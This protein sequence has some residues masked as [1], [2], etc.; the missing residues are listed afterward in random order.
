MLKSKTRLIYSLE[1]LHLMIPIKPCF[2]TWQQITLCIMK[3]HKKDYIKEGKKS[4]FYKVIPAEFN[5]LILLC[6]KLYVV[7]ED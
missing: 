4:F 5:I 3:A 2:G 1:T 7:V 6:V